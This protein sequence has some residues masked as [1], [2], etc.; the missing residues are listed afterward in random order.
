[1]STSADEKLYKNIVKYV[2]AFESRLED[3]KRGKK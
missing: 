3:L 1:V 2:K